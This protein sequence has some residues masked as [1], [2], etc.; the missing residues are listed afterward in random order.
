MEKSLK[1]WYNKDKESDIMKLIMGIIHKDDASTVTKELNANGYYVTKLATSGGFL[2]KGN[3]TIL[4]GTDE[5]K[6]PGAVEI[7]EK[8]TKKHDE[9]NDSVKKV[10]GSTV[11]V[12][13][14]D[15]FEKV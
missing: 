3:V 6:V 13:N 14:V 11:F 10:V 7:I 2:K 5:E 9:T 8:H 1:K 15:R 12:L 4:V